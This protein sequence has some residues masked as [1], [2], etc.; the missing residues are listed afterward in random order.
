MAD[1]FGSI[2]DAWENS[3][4]TPVVI[5][6]PDEPERDTKMPRLGNKRLPI[7]DSIDLHGLLLD[8]AEQ[9]VDRFLRSAH[10]QGLRKVLIIHGKGTHGDGVLRSGIRSFLEK[11][12]LAGE[13]GVPKRSDGGTG[14]VWA[15]VRQRSR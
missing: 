10:A 8:E 11:H 1:D 12:P 15:I 6:K 13:L 2:L 3:R 9:A 4:G 7:E 14:A 5:D